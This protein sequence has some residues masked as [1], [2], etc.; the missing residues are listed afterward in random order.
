[1]SVANQSKPES[2]ERKRRSLNRNDETRTYAEDMTTSHLEKAPCTPWYDHPFWLGIASSFLLFAAFPPLN[3]WPLAW[4]APVFWIRLI[5]QPK[6]A[7]KW[8]Y[9]AIW[10]AGTIYWLALFY[11]I[12]IPFWG[13]YFGWFAMSAYLGIYLPLFIGLTRIAV[14]RMRVS[15]IVA[16]PITWIGLELGRGYLFTGL[17]MSLLGH[18]QVEWVTIIQVAD[19]AGAYAVSFVVMLVAACLGRM[20]L[21]NER[22]F[23]AWP[24]IPAISLFGCCLL[25][26]VWRT[27]QVTASEDAPVAHIALIQGSV[28]TV[29]DLT[30]KEAIQRQQ[31]IAEQYTQLTTDALAKHPDTDLVIWP[32]SKFMVRDRI[33]TEG[34]SLPYGAP[35]DMATQPYAK[36]IRQQALYVLGNLDEKNTDA[37]FLAG[38]HT[39]Q[40]VASGSSRQF[41]TALL[42]NSNGEIEGRYFKMH[43]VVFGEYVPLGDLLP[44]LYDLTPMSGELTAG[45]QPQVLSVNGL[46]YSANICF[47][48]TVPH[49]IRNQL[50]EL[51]D[52]GTPADFL[53]NITD[54]GWFKGSACLDHHLACSIMRAVELR[55]PMLIAANT[56]FSGVVDGNGRLLQKSPRREPAFLFA[57]VQP[58]ARHSIY[59]RLGDWPAFACLAFCAVLACV[60]LFDRQRQKNLLKG[61]E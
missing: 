44:W 15:V 42:M 47:E 60:G 58:D 22:R 19:L 7:G 27:N 26:G 21:R 14:H 28:D 8:A 3:L 13:L 57:E 9:P 4:V 5:L 16:A 31:K 29:F 1:M 33:N 2:K 25:Y 12:P 36:E 23:A 53:V 55:T 51:E 39:S 50:R 40:V 6:L 45:T 61:T 30:Q 11:F 20:L 54:D 59:Q 52:A 41:N 24:A 18:T 35:S 56:G 34:D 37:H 17:S 10:I 43:R 49:V 32:E 46:N 48:S 38:T